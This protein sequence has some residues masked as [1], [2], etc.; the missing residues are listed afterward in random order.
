MSNVNSSTY[1]ESWEVVKLGSLV[2]SEKGKKPIN[3]VREQSSAHQLPYID[4]QAFEKGVINSWTDGRDCRICDESDFLMVWDGSRSGLVGKGMKGAL[5]STLVRINFPLME[6]QYAFYFLQSKYHQINS[7]AKGSG[8]PHVDPD[9]LW[10]Y[11]FPIPPLNEQRRI[12]SKI[13]EL[14]SELDKG[15]ESLEKAREQLKVYRQAV[16]K[17]AFEGKLTEQWREENK[18]KLETPEQFLICIKHEREARYEQVLSDWEMSVKKWEQTNRASKKRAKPKPVS[19]PLLID[20]EDI[21]CF[22]DLPDGWAWVRLGQLFFVS[23]QNGIYKPASE[24]GSGTQI[25]RID[26]FYHGKLIRRTGFKKLRLNHEEI[27]KYKVQ[28]LDLI[29]N[30]VNSIEFLGKCALVEGLTESTVFESN[31]MKCSVIEDVIS[32]AYVVAYLASHEGQNRLCKNAKH[33]VNQASINQTDVSNTLVPIA[34]LKEQIFIVQQIRQKLSHADA[35]I[36]QIE[37]FLEKTKV[38][39][40]SILKRA[41]SGQ[42]VVQEPN[43]ETAAMLLDRIRIAKNAETPRAQA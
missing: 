18:D 38:L 25:I 5:G 15:V 16:L 35:L 30:R 36:Y 11:E 13:E 17:H 4:I 31:I 1:P 22:S 42:L 6:N 7:R 34:S 32:K 43:D 20:Q 8:T 28:D 26:D 40:Q 12:V 24:Y 41:F 21:K 10:N 14:F 29:I 2:E 3:H 39:R 9:L 37:D 27:E 19:E 33:A 23:P